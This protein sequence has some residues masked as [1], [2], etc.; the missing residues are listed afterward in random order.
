MTFN[1]RAFAQADRHGPVLGSIACQ[2]D[3]HGQ[4]KFRVDPERGSSCPACAHF[5]LGCEDKM[6]FVGAGFQ[7][8][9]RFDQHRTADAVVHCLGHQAPAQVQ[10]G[11]LEGC[12]ITDLDRAFFCAG[13]A[14]VNVTLAQGGKSVRMPVIFHSD[15]PLR[16]VGELDASAQHGV[17]KDS[18]DAGKADE[19]IRVDM[20]GDQ[21]DLIHVGG[22]HD[23]LA[24]LAFGAFPHDQ[25]AQRVHAHFVGERFH[26][27]ADDLPDG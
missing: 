3:I 6:D 12:H 21:S 8:T 9:Q 24:V 18:A 20:R 27:A 16:A 7:R 1:C 19:S 2:G 25:V 22:Q 15:Y 11:P 14:G 26:F 23:A 17:R 10:E 4:A 5:F 13:C